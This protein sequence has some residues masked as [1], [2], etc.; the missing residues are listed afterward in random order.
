MARGGA[1]LAA[2]AREALG[3]GAAAAQ[4]WR[5]RAAENVGWRGG[6]AWMRSGGRVDGRRAVV[7]GGDKRM[8][9]MSGARKEVKSN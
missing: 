9:L 1:G 2:N 4:A 7:A 8:R 6:E 5:S 3:L